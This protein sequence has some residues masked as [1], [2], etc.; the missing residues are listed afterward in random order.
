[1][2]LFDTQM[3][4]QLHA[5]RRAIIFDYLE[6][7]WREGESDRRAVLWEFAPLAVDIRRQ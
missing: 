5:H 1:V 2:I 7:R 6:R 3:P 4:G